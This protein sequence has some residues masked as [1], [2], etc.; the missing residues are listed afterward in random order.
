MLRNYS[1]SQGCG[2]GS[3]LNTNSKYSNHKCGKYDIIVVSKGPYLLDQALTGDITPLT[4]ST[5]RGNGHIPRIS[6]HP[7]GEDFIDKIKNKDLHLPTRQI[8]L[9]REAPGSCPLTLFKVTSYNGWCNPQCVV[10]KYY[11]FIWTKTINEINKNKLHKIYKHYA[12]IFSWRSIKAPCLRY[13]VCWLYMLHLG[14]QGCSNLAPAT[15]VDVLLKDQ[16]GVGKNITESNQGLLH[17]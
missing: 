4:H 13:A 10:S 9:Y 2:W 16:P 8:I 1:T 17:S 6:S 14:Y 11:V 15:F 12:V 5:R 7:L 3:C